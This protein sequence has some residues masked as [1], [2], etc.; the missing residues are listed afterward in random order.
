VTLLTDTLFDG[1]NYSLVLNNI[2]DMA[3]IPNTILAGTTVPSP[4][5]AWWATGSLKK[6]PARRL[7][8]PAPAV[9]R[10]PS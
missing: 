8:T 2:Q 6:A 1:T 7:P 3:L 10:A 9:S 5:P 4:I